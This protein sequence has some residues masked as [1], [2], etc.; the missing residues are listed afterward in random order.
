MKLGKLCEAVQGQLVGDSE[1]EI[2]SVAPL[3]SATVSDLTFLFDAKMQKKMAGV[4]YGALV[5]SR[6]L[7]EGGNQ[8]IV[9]DP[10]RSLIAIL[11]LFAKFS[12]VPSF[13]RSRKLSSI[14]CDAEVPET[15]MVGPFVSIGEHSIVG[16]GTILYPNVTVGRG[17]RL[18][19]NC[20]L[21][22]GVT[23]YDNVQLGDNVVVHAGARIGVDGFGYHPNGLTWDKIPHIGSVIIEDQVE[24]GANTCID[25]GCI[26]DTIIGHGTKIDNLTQIAHNNHIGPN[27]AMAAMTAVAG[28][29]TLG[30]HVIV[31]GQAG[32]KDHVSV[33]DNAV[34]LARSGITQDIPANTMVSGFPAREH[35]TEMRHQAKLHRLTRL[36]A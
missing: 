19:Q 32:F 10:R 34:I 28:S 23:L 24:I 4:R 11:P 12:P 36:D 17:C 22:P 26:G 16:S 1:C 35:R 7:P 20:I 3:E 30:A 6:I 8:I 21:H 29:V 31:A 14:A 18:G 13:D 15:V 9:A 2:Q 33:G 27:C 5:T 25:R